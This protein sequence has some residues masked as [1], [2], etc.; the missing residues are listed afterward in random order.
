MD[1]PSSRM[2]GTSII[3]FFLL[4]KDNILEGGKYYRETTITNPG[5]GFSIEFGNFQYCPKIN[6]V[7]SQIIENVQNWT[8][9]N[10]SK[11]WKTSLGQVWS[12]DIQTTTILSCVLIFEDYVILSY[13]L[14]YIC[15]EWII[16]QNVFQFFLWNF[17]EH[18]WDVPSCAFVCNI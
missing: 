13:H 18:C 8:N 7:S 1:S 17:S 5:S 16:F 12:F 10:K 2:N 6:V 9:G 11:P 3:T 4:C 15:E 14:V